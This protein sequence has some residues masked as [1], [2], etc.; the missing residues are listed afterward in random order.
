MEK[1]FEKEPSV[2]YSIGE[3][4]RSSVELRQYV[5]TAVVGLTRLFKLEKD[6][7]NLAKSGG[8][9]KVINVKEDIR[10]AGFHCAQLR[11]VRKYH[12]N[13]TYIILSYTV[14]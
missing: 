5:L 11:I 13:K 4:C 6:Y 14:R 1:F 8:K 3:D 10:K 2:P 12:K 7:T 9:N